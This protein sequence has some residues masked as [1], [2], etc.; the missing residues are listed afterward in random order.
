MNRALAVADEMAEF[1]ARANYYLNAPEEFRQELRLDARRVGSL[2]VMMIPGID[3][4][5]FNRIVG[6]GLREPATETMIDDAV[7][8]LHKTGCRN[9]TIQVSPAAE[10]EQIGEWLLARGFTAVKPTAKLHRGDRAWPDH[11]TTLRVEAIGE[12]HASAFA[13]LILTIFHM[14]AVLHPLMKGSVGQPNWRHYL[15]FDGF[16]AVAAGALY[17]HGD[18]GWIGFGC[19]L[20]SHRRHGAHQA[21]MARRINDGRA[22]GCRRFVTETNQDLPES[23]NPAFRNLIHAGF[24]LSYL[25]PNFVFRSPAAPKGN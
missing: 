14:P 3:S 6:F 9:F 17:M 7:A 15:A 10:P 8:V 21:I 24:D 19:T 23:P 12:D 22:R 1:E 2:L 20:E 13:D 18:T 4:E 16:Q 5:F 25:R 11:S